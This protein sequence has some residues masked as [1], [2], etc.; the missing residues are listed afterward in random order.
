MKKIFFIPSGFPETPK[1]IFFAPSGF[2]ETPKKIFDVLSGHPERA[3]NFI[4]SYM[5]LMTFV[6]S[7]LQ[8][9]IVN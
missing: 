1:K 5:N 6:I 4:K 3:N 2:P 9:R 8:I 7:E